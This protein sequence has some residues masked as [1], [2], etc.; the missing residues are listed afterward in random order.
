MSETLTGDHKVETAYELEFGTD[1]DFKEICTK[2]Y[3]RDELSKLSTAIE[4]DVSN[5]DYQY[6]LFYSFLNRC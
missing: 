3:G 1:V 5:Y 4:E 6:L 2:E